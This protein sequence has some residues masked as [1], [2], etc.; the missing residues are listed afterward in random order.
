MC[1]LPNLYG[2]HSAEDTL[3]H[4][5]MPCT[6]AG[7]NTFGHTKY[8]SPPLIAGFILAVPGIEHVFR[9]AVNCSALI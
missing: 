6:V 4:P 1:W 2:G 9:E 3:C 5:L 8:S 7:C